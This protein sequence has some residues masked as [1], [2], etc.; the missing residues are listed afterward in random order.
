MTA[1]DGE[2]ITYD[3]SGN[4]LSYYNGT[5]WAFTWENGRSLATA[6]D[7]TTNISYAYDA[8]GLRTSKVVNGVTYNYLYASGQLMR[9]TYGSNTLDFFYDASGHPYALKYNGTTYYY[10]TNLQ[11]DVM[12]LIDANENTVA[13]YEYDPYGNIVSATGTMAEINPLRYRGYYYDAELD[14]YYLQS[15]YY[16]PQIGR[17]INADVYASTGAGVLG[18]NMFAYCNNTPVNATDPTGQWLLAIAGGGWLATAGT[19]GAANIWNP[20]G[21]VLLG[22][23]VVVAAVAVGTAVAK[24][25]RS[26]SSTRT[27]VLADVKVRE[28]YGRHYQLAYVSSSGSLI[29]CGRKMTFEEALAALGITGATNSISQRFSYNP[30]KSSSAQRQLEHLGNWGIYAD[31][32]V[33]AKALAVVFGFNSKPEVHGSGMYGHYHGG[34]YNGR[35]GEYEH[36]F[37]IWYGGIL[38]Y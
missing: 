34:Y 24:Y 3:A 23:T 13:S 14:M 22:V 37:H 38:R 32:Q 16:D 7:G 15:R 12:Y 20:V 8:N 5:R 31:S 33:S 6:T 27:K 4:P 21:W 10:I 35:K 36:I 25:S 11:G 30:G 19:A 26:T 9:E 2:T 28:Q 29:R 17:F 18:C 1:Y